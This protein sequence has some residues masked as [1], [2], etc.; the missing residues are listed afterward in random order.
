MLLPLTL[1]LML[2]M[3]LLLTLLPLLL[4]ITPAISSTFVFD[5]TVVAV[6]SQR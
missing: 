3:L 6:S 1:L 2:L 4:S 5:V